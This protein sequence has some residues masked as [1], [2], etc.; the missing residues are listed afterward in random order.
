MNLEVI[1]L[2]N[3]TLPRGCVPLE[4]MFDKHDMYKGNPVVDQSD[5]AFE[6]HI[7]SG[8]EP[9]MVKIGKGTTKAERDAI[10]DLI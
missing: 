3:N 8:I 9:R 6:F 7:G 4:Q 1:D 10:V 2:P 5:K